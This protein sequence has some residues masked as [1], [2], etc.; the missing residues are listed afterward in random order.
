MKNNACLIDFS[1]SQNSPWCPSQFLMVFWLYFADRAQ[2]AHK[3]WPST[4]SDTESVG[5]GSGLGS[6]TTSSG[7]SCKT[8]HTHPES[9]TIHTR[10]SLNRY[11][12]ND[13]LKSV[14]FYRRHLKGFKTRVSWNIVFYRGLRWPRWQCDLFWT[15]W[16]PITLSKYCIIKLVGICL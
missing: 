6:P 14:R 8:T 7:A 3:S 2:Q 11:K 9:G 15:K 5:G 1:M 12:R 13:M 4:L 16:A 10:D